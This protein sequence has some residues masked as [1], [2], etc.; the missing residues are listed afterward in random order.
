MWFSTRF[1]RCDCLR[2]ILC[3]SVGKF[4]AQAVLCGRADYSPVLDD[5]VY[6]EQNLQV[7]SVVHGVISLEHLAVEY[8]AE[9]RRLRITKLRGSTFRGGYHDF[10]IN[11]G[12]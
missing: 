8:G 3:V 4:G 10:V 7:H 6:G 9:R 5:K 2:A 11:T 12:A 1:R